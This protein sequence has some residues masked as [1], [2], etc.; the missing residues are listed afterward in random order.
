M[1]PPP[2]P[3]HWGPSK[4]SRSLSSH[5]ATILSLAEDPLIWRDSRGYWAL[6]KDMKG[7]FTHAGR[8]I[9]LMR[10]RD[11]YEWNLPRIRLPSVPKSVRAEGGTQTL[12]CP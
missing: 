3:L 8:S 1:S 10:S 4:T 6:V 9:A 11:G 7:G 12:R 5:T 2:P